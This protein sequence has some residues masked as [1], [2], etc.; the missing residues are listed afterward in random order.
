ML[1]FKTNR[2]WIRL[3]AFVC[4]SLCIVAPSWAAL[5]SAG[6]LS[7]DTSSDII[8]DTLN[9]RDW[10]GWDVTKGFTYAQTLIN[11]A[12]GGIWDGYSIAHSSDAML[13][14]NA[15]LGNNPCSATPGLYL[16]CGSAPGTSW[17]TLVGDNYTPPDINS[18]ASYIWYLND[19]ST[20]LPVGYLYLGTFYGSNGE[21]LYNNPIWGTTSYADWFNAGGPDPVYNTVGWLLYKPKSVSAPATI[22]LLGLGLAGL[23]VSRRKSKSN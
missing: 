11:I 18:D 12:H 8:V 23:G 1:T 10:L 6:N 15:L 20:A 4:M 2:V 7:R 14:T 16:S 22:S 19:L 9:Q 5:I 3:A 21:V 17:N 13:F